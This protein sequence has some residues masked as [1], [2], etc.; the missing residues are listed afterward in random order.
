MKLISFRKPSH[1]VYELSP[2][3]FCLV[4]VTW[5]VHYIKYIKL[6]RSREAMSVCP[7]GCEAAIVTD[8]FL[9]LPQFF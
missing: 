7:Y 2:E 6:T 5:A 3:G 4:N 9:A 1:S 8:N